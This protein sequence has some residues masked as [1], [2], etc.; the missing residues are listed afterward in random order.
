LLRLREAVEERLLEVL[1]DAELRRV[2]LL[3]ERVEPRFEPRFV[4]RA[5]L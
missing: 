5:P 1:F 4:W 3:P 2:L